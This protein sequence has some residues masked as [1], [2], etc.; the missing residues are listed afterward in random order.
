MALWTVCQEKPSVLNDLC[1]PIKGSNPVVEIDSST[2]NVPPSHRD[3]YPPQGQGLQCMVDYIRQTHKI[4]I[5]LSADQELIWDSISLC[6]V[7]SIC[8]TCKQPLDEPFLVS[9]SGKIVDMKTIH[10][11]VYEFSHSSS[12]SLFCYNAKVLLSQFY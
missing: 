5:R 4:P 9:K 11:C 1:E 8:T 7:E 6:P 12:L 2:D 10:D 3:I